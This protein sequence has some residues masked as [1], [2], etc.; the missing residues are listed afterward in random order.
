[1]KGYLHDTSGAAV[2]W[3]DLDETAIL[4]LHLSLIDWSFDN[5]PICRVLADIDQTFVPAAIQAT[6]PYY[7]D[8]KEVGLKT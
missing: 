3:G 6:H 8:V 7:F 1:V 4:S 2:G 5:N